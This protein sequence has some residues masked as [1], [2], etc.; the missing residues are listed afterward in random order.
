MT[1][2]EGWKR[3]HGGHYLIGLFS[4]KFSTAASITSGIPTALPASGAPVS[5]VPAGLVGLQQLFSGVW[6][7][8]ASASCGVPPREVS[9]GSTTKEQSDGSPVL[10]ILWLGRALGFN[11]LGAKFIGVFVPVVPP[12]HALFCPCSRIDGFLPLSFQPRKDA[13]SHYGSFSGKISPQ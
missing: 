12:G 1:R 5:P 13:R 2:P 9:E 3:L 11:S 10:V 7:T 8:A 4:R 6:D